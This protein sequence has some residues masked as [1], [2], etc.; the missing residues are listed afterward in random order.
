MLRIRDCK[1]VQ[2]KSC[3]AF[4]KILIPASVATII[5]VAVPD[6]MIVIWD[7]SLRACGLLPA[8]TCRFVPCDAPYE[9]RP[10]DRGSAHTLYTIYDLMIDLMLMQDGVSAEKVQIYTEEASITADGRM[11][12]AALRCNKPIHGHAKA[13]LKARG[14]CHGPIMVFCS[15]QMFAAFLVKLQKL[16]GA[17]LKLVRSVD[18]GL[19][20]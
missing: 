15:S 13:S 14:V 5:L 18:L 1:P 20:S 10:I 2:V 7:P 19:K 12:I 17:T 8:W 3:E 6:P 11:Y 16:T 4:S 9:R